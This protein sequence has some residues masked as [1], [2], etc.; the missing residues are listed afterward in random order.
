M[1]KTREEIIASYPQSLIEAL[2]DGGEIHVKTVNGEIAISVCGNEPE[3]IS[4]T[5]GPKG[6]WQ[7]D[8]EMASAAAK[9]LEKAVENG[10]LKCYPSRSE[11]TGI[12]TLSYR[13][14]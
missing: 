3:G 2:K 10:E 11:R 8:Q 5:M 9:S 1:P 13:L 7:Q 4:K 14:P 12:V 6:N